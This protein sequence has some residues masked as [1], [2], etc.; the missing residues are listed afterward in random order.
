MNNS[1][2]HI[3]DALID[4]QKCGEPQGIPSICSA[5]PWV[6]KAAM[7]HAARTG[8]P[9]LVEATCNQVNQFG[10]Y[11]G[12]TPAVF[13]RY[14]E[15]IAAENSFPVG[16]ILLGG[17][18]LG[19]SAWQD[20]P[21]GQAMQ[22]SAEML[23]DY[24]R[25]GFVKLHLDASMK[26]AGDGDGPLA[27]E[28]SAGRAAALASAAEAA[29][30]LDAPAPRYVIGTEVPVPGGAKEHEDGVAV[31]TVDSVRQTIEVT[32]Q[33]FYRQGL[34]AAWERVIAVV[35]QPGVE[36]GD[37]F[38]LEYQPEAAHEL[39]RFIES[40]PGLVYEAHSTDYQ[41]R[42][43]LRRLVR[44]HFAILKVGP[45]LTFAF[46]EA[47]FALAAIEDAMFPASEC[48]N[49]VAILDRAMVARPEYWHKYY[50]GTA[51]QQSFARK[52]SLSDRIRY[53]WPMPEVQGALGRLLA[54]LSLKPIPYP[55]LSQYL[56]AQYMRLGCGVLQSTPQAILLDKVTAVLEDYAAVCSPPDG[57]PGID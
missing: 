7:Q 6:L 44:D 25:A 53:Y 55:L 4:A 8:T 30:G 16:R 38:V 26:L 19:P 46:R 34:E 43:A 15:R 57:L 51:E 52:Y 23:R 32:R 36:F 54:N 31:T 37:D 35:V 2:T 20:E 39:S 1:G 9:L 27:P 42:A 24:V 33:A 13:H 40:L 17:D 49:I 47:I 5:H 21:A 18:H 29:R 28:I 45:G 10:G 22:K 48:S 12:M 41:S 11:T 56:P 50:H 3:F 14:V